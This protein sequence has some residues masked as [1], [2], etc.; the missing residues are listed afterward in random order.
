MIIHQPQAAIL[1]QQRFTMRGP[2]RAA[3]ED[4]IAH[5]YHHRRL[6]PITPNDKPRADPPEALS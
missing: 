4:P 2:A 6:N 1:R 3:H 5:R